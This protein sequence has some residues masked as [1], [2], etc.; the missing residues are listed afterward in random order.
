MYDREKELIILLS[1]KFD[2]EACVETIKKILEENVI[3]WDIAIKYLCKTKVMGLFWHNIIKIKMDNY[4]P[5]NAKRVLE[6]YYLGNCERNK[7][8]MNEFEII[9]QILANENIKAAPLKGIVLLKTIYKDFGERQLNDIDLLVSYKEK[10]R[11]ERAFLENGYVHGNITYD[12]GGNLVI[13]KL[14]RVQEIIWKTKM[15]NLPPFYKLTAQKW[16]NVIDVD[17]SFAFDYQMKY[18]NVADIVN[19]LCYE[20]GGYF[21]PKEDFFIQMCCHLYKEASNASWVLLGNDLN[22]MKFCDVREFLESKIDT[23]SWEIICKKSVKEGY[24]KA[25]YFALYYC[26]M[27]Y[28]EK[29]RFSYKSDLCIKD[30]SFIDEYGNDLYV[31][32]HN[33]FPAGG[34]HFGRG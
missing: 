5:A 3:H 11:V 2:L 13:E 12:K 17:C 18:D 21:L 14:D 22:L 26:E 1:R 25:I 24:N 27:I 8:I 15:N 9:K 7:I 19:N 29:C 10:E 20:Q 16:C 33:W 31:A 32:F 30:V 4:V 23:Q 28:G 34:F 6:F